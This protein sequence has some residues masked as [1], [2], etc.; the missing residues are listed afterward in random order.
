MKLKHDCV[1]YVLLSLEAQGIGMLQGVQ[2]SQILP[3]LVNDQYSEDDITYTFLQLLDGGYINANY[4]KSYN[5][6]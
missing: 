5:T 1:R 6:L 4:E 3:K 2:L